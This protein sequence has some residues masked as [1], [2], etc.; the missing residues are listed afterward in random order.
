MPHADNFLLV[1]PEGFVA[2]ANATPIIGINGGTEALQS[3]IA[4]GDFLQMDEWQGIK[5]TAYL[6]EGFTVVDARFFDSGEPVDS[7]L[8]WIKIA[9]ITV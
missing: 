7:L 8:L 4:G 5:E 3:I 2:I 6:P 1:V 9:P